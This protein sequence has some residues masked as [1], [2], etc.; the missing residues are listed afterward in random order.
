MEI[1]GN[2]LEDHK[3]ICNCNSIPFWRNNATEEDF[4]G[5]D[6]SVVDNIVDKFVDI[7]VIGMSG[8]TKLFC[9]SSLFEYS[10]QSA[11]SFV[12]QQ[13]LNLFTRINNAG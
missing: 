5:I 2:R 13:Y 8:W 9:S 7:V 12:N 1:K 6:N 4:D 10:E 11:G 3:I